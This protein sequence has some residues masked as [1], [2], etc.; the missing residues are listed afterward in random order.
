LKEENRLVAIERGLKEP[1]IEAKKRRKA[2]RE[3]RRPTTIALR[4]ERT[5]T[6]N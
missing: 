4:E 5:T 6:T 1:T 2:L 3:E